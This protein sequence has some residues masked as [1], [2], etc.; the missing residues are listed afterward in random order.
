MLGKVEVYDVLY[1]IVLARQQKQ[2]ERSHLVSYTVFAVQN[3]MHR[4]ELWLHEHHKHQNLYKDTVYN[5]VRIRQFSLVI[6]V[7]SLLKH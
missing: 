4:M 7:L 1:R 5:S 3:L 6:S 2:N